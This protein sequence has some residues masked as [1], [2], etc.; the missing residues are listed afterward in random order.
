MFSDY[1]KEKIRVQEMNTKIYLDHLI[2]QISI[3]GTDLMLVYLEWSVMF[4]QG[5]MFAYR[6]EMNSF[7]CL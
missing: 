5:P 2:I 6:I 4:M 3:S 7:M 1:I